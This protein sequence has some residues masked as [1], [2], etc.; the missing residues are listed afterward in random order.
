MGYKLNQKCYYNTYMEIK[1]GGIMDDTKSKVTNASEKVVG[2]INTNTKI[3]D[4]STTVEVEKDEKNKVKKVT[5]EKSEAKNK[6][7][8][9]ARRTKKKDIEGEIE[10][11]PKA[12]SKVKEKDISNT[13]ISSTVKKKVTR[14][15]SKNTK[16]KKNDTVKPLKID[17]D[18]DQLS[19]NIDLKEIIGDAEVKV[20][21]FGGSKDFTNYPVRVVLKNLGYVKVVKVRYTVDNWNS[22]NEKPL[23][24]NYQNNDLEQWSVDLKL[25]EKEINNFEYAIMYNVNDWTY[26]DNNY[27]R[28]YKF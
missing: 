3:V 8:S 21:P 16:A 2:D 11:I 28:N 23:V 25:N 27:E 20:I 6:T 19:N 9:R 5:T 4:D 7:A 12:K 13:K 15:S 22:Y 17:K 26:W 10:E 24:F 1:G 18:I 14:I